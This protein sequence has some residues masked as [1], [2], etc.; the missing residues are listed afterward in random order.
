MPRTQALLGNP[1]GGE[2]RSDSGGRE[3]L[4]L[5]H[6]LWLAYARLQTSGRP[7][8][9][10]R[11]KRMALLAYEHGRR[12]GEAPGAVRVAGRAVEFVFERERMRRGADG[13]RAAKLADFVPFAGAAIQVQFTPCQQRPGRGRCP[14]EWM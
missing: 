2:V 1:D 6:E 9:A 13:G 14:S 7:P 10:R 11:L 8:D 12:T 5:L 4:P 3:G